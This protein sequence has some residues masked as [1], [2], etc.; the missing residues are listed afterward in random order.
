[1]YNIIRLL[2]KQ[3]WDENKMA[4]NS[5]IADYVSTEYIAFRT[6]DKKLGFNYPKS[7]GGY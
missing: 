1:L 7:L 2:Y 3:S 5:I 6:V 4:T